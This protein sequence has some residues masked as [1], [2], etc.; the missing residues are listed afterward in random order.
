MINHTVV[1]GNG[2]TSGRTDLHLVGFPIE[3]DGLTRA[4][5]QITDLFKRMSFKRKP[6]LNFDSRFIDSR[7]TKKGRVIT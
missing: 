7:L 6:T 5:E 3:A 4:T 2:P 1:P